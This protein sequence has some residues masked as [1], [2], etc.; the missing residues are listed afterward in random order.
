MANVYLDYLSATPILPEVLDAMRPFLE[1]DGFGN[2]SS[3]HQHG[4]RVRDAL[5]VA[6]SQVAAF[7]HA[8]SPEEIIFTSDGTESINLAVKGVAW[9]N[10]RRGRHVVA[11][12]V[13][14]PA[15]LESIDFLES[16]GYESSRVGVDAAG[17]VALAAFGEVLKEGTILACAHLANHDIGTIQ[18]VAELGKVC[19]DRGVPLLVDAEA[20][21]GWMAINVKAAGALLLSFSP[22]RFGGPKGVGVLY[23]HRRA[24]L[25]SLVHG[26]VQEGG[27]R[28]GTESV[29]AIVGAG[30]ACEVAGRNHRER[31]ARV[32]GLQRRLWEGLKSKVPYIKLQGPE[33]GPGRLCSSLNVSLEFVEGEGLLLMLDTQGVAIASGTSCASKAL[34]ISPVLQAIG[35]DHALAQGSVLMSL[36]AS[37]TEAE[38]DAALE[39]IPRTVSRL[40]EL[41]PM[42]DEFQRGLIDSTIA[43]RATLS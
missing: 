18:P 23:R 13:E 32:S 37:S 38:I 17:F 2:P 25:T 10:Q 29:A 33:P 36:G 14:H 5:D 27:F 20:A 34:K 6:R 15:V 30:V 21:A 42:W 26:G 31:A 7:L 19:A 11:T 41:S 8:D 16:Q 28:A 1:G 39:I 3:L 40:R 9:A 35:C 12:T 4:L 43:P 24:R 22:H